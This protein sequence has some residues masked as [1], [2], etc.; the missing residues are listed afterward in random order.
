MDINVQS[1]E[2]AKISDDGIQIYVRAGADLQ[3]V[4]DGVKANLLAHEVTLRPFNTVT[5]SEIEDVIQLHE[6]VHAV[7]WDNPKALETLLNGSTQTTYPNLGVF[8]LVS[9]VFT[10]DTDLQIDNIQTLQ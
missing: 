6:S 4:L 8:E 10:F 7:G 9:G 5:L 3:A 2:A 1:L